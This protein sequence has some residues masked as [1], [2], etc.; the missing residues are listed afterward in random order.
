V[1]WSGNIACSGSIS[2]GEFLISEVSSASDSES[3]SDWTFEG[4]LS[5]SGLL[6]L[7]ALSYWWMSLHLMPRYG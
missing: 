2:T 6:L 1:S 5:D 7:M 3:G 4:S